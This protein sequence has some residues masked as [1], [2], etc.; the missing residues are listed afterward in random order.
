MCL[1]GMI[2]NP[3]HVDEDPD[4]AFYFDADQ[5]PDPAF[6]FDTDPDST[7]HFDAYQVPPHRPF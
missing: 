4:L 2:A 6:H 1:C 7:F 5:G 3:N